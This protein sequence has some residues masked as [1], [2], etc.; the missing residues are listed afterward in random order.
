MSETDNSTEIELS[1]ESIIEAILF[2][3]GR[4]VTPEQIVAL[5]PET[6]D[7]PELS[8]VKLALA[9][10]QEDYDD[11]GIELKK[12]ASGYR[13]QVRQQMAPWV[14]GLFGEKAPRYT[15]AL[16]ETLA[17]IA[18]RQPIT[19]GEIED[20]RGVS[21]SSNIVRTLQERE[22]VRIVGRRD[23][24][25]RPAMYA[26]TRQ[27]LDYFNLSNLNE[28]PPL[29]EIRDLE[30]MAEKLEVGLQQELKGISPAIHKDANV[31]DEVAEESVS[32][33]SVQGKTKEIH[34]KDE[35]MVLIN[36]DV[37]KA[38]EEEKEKSDQEVFS[39]VDELLANVKTNFTDYSPEV[40]L[41]DKI[42]DNDEFVGS[43]RE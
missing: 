33:D 29:G 14:V 20:I 26:T 39:T 16:L 15:R 23:V 30:A 31:D 28:L 1:L 21:V 41:A 35:A 8:E 32:M 10:V 6:D 25:G 7:V 42:A 4:P 18:Y 9:N 11:R 12:V 24:P 27:F 36:H 5:F 3:A 22:W 43:V 19:R 2:T 40:P 38:F 17:L 37:A 13:F 34:E